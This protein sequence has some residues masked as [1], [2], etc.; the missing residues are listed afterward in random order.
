MNCAVNSWGLGSCSGINYTNQYKTYE[1]NRKYPRLKIDLPVKVRYGKGKYIRARIHD[2]SPD[3]LQ[4]RCDQKSAQLLHSSG[5]LIEEDKRPSVVVV[6]KVPYKK[7]YNK[8][9][10]RCQICYFALLGD[11]NVERITVAFGLKFN[12]FKGDCGKYAGWFI[13]NEMKPEDCY[14]EEET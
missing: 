9:I 1:D 14:A 5:K 3:G 2:I 10:V 8:I 4:I 7:A 13:Y 12:K 6:F 11:E